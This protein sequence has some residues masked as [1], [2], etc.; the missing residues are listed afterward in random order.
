MLRRWESLATKLLR[1]RLRARRWGILGWWL[2]T[3]HPDKTTLR[4]QRSWWHGVGK[5]LQLH[6][7]RRERALKERNEPWN[8]WDA[9]EA[10]F[11]EGGW[12]SESGDD[13]WEPPAERPSASSSSTQPAPQV[14]V[15]VNINIHNANDAHRGNPTEADGR[16]SRG[17]HAGGGANGG[18][19]TSNTRGGRGSGRG[20]GRW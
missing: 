20:R 18:G 2:G 16:S 9:R 14:H 8:E 1:W 13:H 7:R 17:A 12:S 5:L 6:K 11:R 10:A 15:Q 19:Y 4:W 3:Y